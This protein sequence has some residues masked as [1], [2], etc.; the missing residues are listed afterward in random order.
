MEV[1][2]VPAVPA[3]TASRTL[4]DMVG[5]ASQRYGDA[6]AL[7]HK[8][9][10]QWVDV[11]YRRLAETAREVA[12][13]L[14]DLGVE[15]GDR[16]AILSHTRPEWT[17]ANLGILAVGAASVAVYQTNSAEEVHYVLEHSESRAVFVEDAEQLAKVRAVEA[18]LPHLEWII[19]MAPDAEVGHATTLAQLRERGRDRDPV[20]F[21]ERA[22]AVT[23]EDPDLFI[24]TSGTTGPPKG[25]VLTHAN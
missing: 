23:P 5:L 13:G 19:V 3:N 11:S 17:Y 16:V 15:S 21:D 4:A 2:T 18:R 6:P 14:A 25:C 8:S 1:E 7:R 9:D 10:G 12:L 22:G 20:E 24:Y